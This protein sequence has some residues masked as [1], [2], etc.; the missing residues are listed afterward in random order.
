[1]AKCSVCGVDV[2]FDV[3]QH[4]VPDFDGKK[5]KVCKNCGLRGQ[6]KALKYDPTSG[7]VIFVEPSEIEIRKKC[8]ICGH[9]FCY[10]PIDL[11]HNKRKRNEAIYSA[12][13]GLGGAMSGNFAASAVQQLN[14]NQAMNAI[15]DYNKCP[16]C[17]S[18]D[19]KTISKEELSFEMG[20]VQRQSFNAPQISAADELKKYKELLDIGVLTQEEFDAKKQELLF[21]THSTADIPKPSVQPTPETPKY[22]RLTL[23]RPK[24]WTGMLMTFKVYVDDI[25][26][27]GL[28]NNSSISIEL[29]VGKHTVCIKDWWVKTVF[30]IDLKKDEIISVSWNNTG[31]IVP[32]PT[33]MVDIFIIK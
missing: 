29:P 33:G 6:G 4:Y 28:R 1:M 19:L 11:E 23:S 30:E 22:V 26:K 14:T 2:S 9:V 31:K 12:L 24:R 13:G 32:K 27:S 16:Q 21:I 5:H 10:S 7:K 3:V 20:A 18:L 25:Q 15:V 17:G 8:N